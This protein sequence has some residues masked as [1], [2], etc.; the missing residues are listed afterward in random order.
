MIFQ[1]LQ[2]PFQYAF[3]QKAFIGILLASINCAAIGSYVVIRRMAFF[4]EALTHTLLPGIVFAY[5][6]GIHLFWGALCAS[7]LTALGIG[8][9]SS[10]KEVRQDTAIGVVLSL[11]FAIGVLMMGIVR[12]FRDFSSILFGSILGV[13]SGD[14]LLTG[15]ITFIVISVLFLLYKELELSSFD[16]S[17][18][19]LVRMKPNLLRYILLLLTALSVVSAVQMIGALLTTALLITPAAAAALIARTFLSLIFFSILF[20]ICAGIIGLYLSFYFQIS[21]G[22]TIVVNCA[23]IFITIWIFRVLYERWQSSRN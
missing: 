15:S 3:M 19:K 9:F 11:M 10:Y 14:L 22:A 1:V 21:S 17:Y 7:I 8:L 20:A 23:I 5:L 18:S 4:G 6:R 12:S 13:T 16:P 2:E